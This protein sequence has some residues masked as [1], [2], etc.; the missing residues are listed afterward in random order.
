MTVTATDEPPRLDLHVTRRVHDGLRIDVA[1]RLGPEIGVL[2]GPSGCGKTTL[3]R[4]ITGL[5][6]PD[7]G[8]VRLGDTT[9]FDS[10][11]GV[12][13]A[14]RHRRIGLIFQDDLLFPHL[15]VADNIRFGL[16]GMGR[17]AAA[18]RLA[19]VATLCGVEHLLGR[20]PATLSGGERQRVGLARALAPSPSLLLCDEPVS[21]LDLEGRHALVARLRDVQ[22]ALR[23]PVLYVTHSPSEAVM[24]G[25]RLFL[26]EAGRIQAEGAPLD[27]IGGARGESLGHLDRICNSFRASVE[28][29]APEQGTTRLRLSG[30]PPLIVPLLDRPV[31]TAVEVEVGADDILLARGPIEGLSAHNAIPGNVERVVPRGA[32]AEVLVRTGEV[33]WIASVLS[34]AVER[35]TLSRETDV[36]MIIK[37]RSCRVTPADPAPPVD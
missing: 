1:L 22:K 25:S 7:S 24:L 31:G 23:I 11:R 36:V 16:R 26:M 12:R 3:L 35:L 10:A 28:A 17:A 5:E 14:L 21:A 18:T 13:R 34:S 29:H 4:L 8:F 33:R 19:E 27:V 6:T 37:A 20:L 15:G 2:F 32:E 30:G 9:L